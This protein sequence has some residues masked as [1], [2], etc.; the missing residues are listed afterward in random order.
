MRRGRWVDGRVLVLIIIIFIVLFLPSL[1]IDRRAI[2]VVV[3]RNS[4]LCVVGRS[5][6]VV[7]MAVLLVISFLT[8]PSLH[9]GLLEQT[10]ALCHAFAFL[11][12]LD[13]VLPDKC[14]R[15]SS[16]NGLVF[17]EFA[18]VDVTSLWW[19][20][21]IFVLLLHFAFASSHLQSPIASLLF[22][23]GR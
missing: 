13:L 7:E 9:F 2:V 14:Q 1:V 22:R 15:W 11:P 23:L 10:L 19:I 20:V 21:V 4:G 8:F 6:L 16:E 3:D 17:A 18:D 5:G 12:I